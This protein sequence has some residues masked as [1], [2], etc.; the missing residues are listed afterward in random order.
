MNYLNKHTQVGEEFILQESPVLLTGIAYDENESV[1][2]AFSDCG[3]TR[4]RLQGM[5]TSLD[6]GTAIHVTVQISAYKDGEQ[7][8][9]YLGS[10]WDKSVYKLF[11]G[12]IHGYMPQMIEQVMLDIKQ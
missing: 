8:S 10:C 3:Y 5:Q 6:N 7:F 4:Q 9:E 12:G 2:H 1:A 11:K